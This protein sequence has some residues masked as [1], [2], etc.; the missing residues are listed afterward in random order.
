MRKVR[1]GVL[2]GLVL[3][4]VFSHALAAESAEFTCSGRWAEK[5]VYA[6]L[7]QAWAKAVEK[8]SDGKITIKFTQWLFSYR[9]PNGLDALRKGIADIVSEYCSYCKRDFSTMNLLGLPTRFPDA[10][11]ACQAP[12]PFDRLTTKPLSF[13][14]AIG[15]SYRRRVGMM[16]IYWPFWGSFMHLCWNGVGN[17]S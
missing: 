14:R 16:P 13:F 17:R 5:S 7:I 1:L 11:S 15:H 12:D 10:L 4:V 3:L 2:P 8:E 6:D 9:I